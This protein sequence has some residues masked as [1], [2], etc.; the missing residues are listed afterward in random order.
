MNSLRSKLTAITL[1]L[2]VTQNIFK[3]W[4]AGEMLRFILHDS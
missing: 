4:F 2:L 1:T 3:K